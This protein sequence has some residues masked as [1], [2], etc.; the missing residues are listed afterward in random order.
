MHKSRLY[1]HTC[2]KR[3]LYLQ[4]TPSSYHCCSSDL[5]LL[6][7]ALLPTALQ[8]CP[9][10]SVLSAYNSHLLCQLF[11]SFARLLRAAWV[12][13]LRLH[14]LLTLA[15]TLSLDF[16]NSTY[17]AVGFGVLSHSFFPSRGAHGGRIQDTITVLTQRDFNTSCSL[18][19]ARLVCLEQHLVIPIVAHP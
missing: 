19:L 1:L 11:C 2:W 18:W 16:L 5:S 12:L 10:L 9:S 6:F 4:H 7:F 15:S 14:L 13:S 8:T 17:R 3:H